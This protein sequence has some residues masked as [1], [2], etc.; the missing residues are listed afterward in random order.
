MVK[1]CWVVLSKTYL[2]FLMHL[3]LEKVPVKT[4]KGIS[5]W[6]ERFLKFYKIFHEWLMFMRF[7]WVH[8]FFKNHLALNRVPLML[9]MF[10]VSHIRCK[11]F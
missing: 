3:V 6:L 5:T 7:E 11:M 9:I 1:Q 2:H 10:L 4:Q 8:R